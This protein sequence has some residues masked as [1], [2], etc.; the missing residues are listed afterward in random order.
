MGEVRELGAI[1]LLS[2]N[3][4]SR[5]LGHDF[6]DVYAVFLTD[7]KFRHSISGVVQPGGPPF[8]PG[9]PY[10]EPTCIRDGDL[11]VFK[12]LRTLEVLSIHCR[13]VTD[14]GLNHLQSLARLRRLDLIGT[15]VTPE[16]IKKLQEALPNCKIVY[17]NPC[18]P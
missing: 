4:V 6:K 5:W 1:V 10:R 15:Q 12:P 17:E 8:P 2:D 3:E 9:Y 16:G 11:A 14:A 13:N 7:Y 18:S